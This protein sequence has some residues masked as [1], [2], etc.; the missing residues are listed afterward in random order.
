MTHKLPAM[1]LPELPAVR[2]ELLEFSIVMLLPRCNCSE[3]FHT[4][5]APSYSTPLS[6]CGYHGNDCTL[7]TVM[8]RG[9]LTAVMIRQI[10]S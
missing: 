8:Y 5:T 2:D 6:H 10:V 1:W 3:V 7:L 4:H 9:G